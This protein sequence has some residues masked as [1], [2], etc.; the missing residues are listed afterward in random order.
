MTLKDITWEVI[1]V[2]AAII[3]DL[4]KFQSTMAITQEQLSPQALQALGWPQCFDD[5]QAVATQAML[6]KTLAHLF[7]MKSIRMNPPTIMAVAVVEVVVSA[8][9]SSRLAHLLGLLSWPRS[10]GTAE[11]SVKTML[12][13]VA[14]DLRIRAVLATRMNLSAG[15]KMVDRSR[16][17][18]LPLIDHRAVY[19]AGPKVQ[20]RLTITTAHILPS[21]PSEVLLMGLEMPFWVPVLLL[22]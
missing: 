16:P 11:R 12:S 21:R 5:V 15:W 1:S 4:R 14:T 6:M 10:S 17:I 18:T 7:P 22:R 13:R 2:V 3:Q 19:Q 20:A 9:N 8:R